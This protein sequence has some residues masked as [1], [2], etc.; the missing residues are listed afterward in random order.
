MNCNINT[1]KGILADNCANL[2]GIKEAWMGIWDEFKVTPTMEGEGDAAHET[3]FATIANVEGS[4]EKLYHYTFAK[5]TGSLTSTLT[6]NE[7]NGVKFYTNEISLVFNRLEADKHLECEALAA[8]RLVVIVK[9]NNDN[10]HI[11]GADNYVSA[12]AQTAA[13]GQNFED[14]SG[15]TTTMSAMSAHLPY[16][17]KEADFKSLVAE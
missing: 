10:C 8:G 13:T 7:Q 14:Q 2:A 17:I 15:Y 9:D 3:H 6:K 16:F 1:L 11:V 4:T 5:Q 12:T